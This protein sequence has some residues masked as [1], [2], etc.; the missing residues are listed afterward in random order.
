MRH[1]LRWFQS[2]FLRPWLR[3]ADPSDG[4]ANQ[5]HVQNYLDLLDGHPGLRT[6]N[7][8]VLGDTVTQDNLLFEHE[9]IETE[10][11]SGNARQVDV[12][13]TRVC[14]FGH[15][16]DQQTRP[17][18]RCQYCGR[19]TCSAGSGNSDPSGQRCSH[20]CTA[21]GAACCS[22]HCTT[23]VVQDKDVCYCHRCQW[24]YWW[25]RFWSLSS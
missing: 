22:L 16:L 4:S 15:L 25:H 6:T 5:R 18:A 2:T 14:S 24:R 19:L 1:L 9:H 23:Y 8:R 20:N 3:R 7:V 21:C 13:G 11:D 17:M 12:Y 10:D